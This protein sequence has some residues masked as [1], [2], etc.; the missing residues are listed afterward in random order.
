MLIDKLSQRTCFTDQGV[1]LSI[2]LYT[3]AALIALLLRHWGQARAAKKQGID[4]A[5]PLLRNI[6]GG[7]WSIFFFL[8]TGCLKGPAR[9]DDR[10]NDASK[11]KLIFLRGICYTAAGALLSFLF[12]TVLQTLASNLGGSGWRIPLL[13][14]KALTGA[15]LSM[16][17]FSLLPLPGSDA[18]LFLRTKDFTPKEKAFRQ[19]GTWPF[20]LFSTLGLLLACI[21]VPAAGEQFWSLSGIM[22]LLPILLIG[23]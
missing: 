12:F 10:T 13:A 19:N 2:T 14:A 3:I 17:W 21:A 4:S 23:G 15:N 5:P 22:T 20:F 6:P 16:L 1:A 8:L 18:E 11:N 7:V 9:E